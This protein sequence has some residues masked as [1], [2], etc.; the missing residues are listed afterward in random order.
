MDLLIR[1][2]E[3]LVR[4]ALEENKK[5]SQVPT[6]TPQPSA[7]VAAPRYLGMPMPAQPSQAR[8]QPLV[9]RASLSTQDPAYDNGGLRGLLTVLA[10]IA[11]VVLVAIWFMYMQ[12][13]L[14]GI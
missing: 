10:L 11:L 14:P 5:R 8:S 13:W 7:Q 12:G 6:T 9:T 2:I 1:L 4:S 3:F